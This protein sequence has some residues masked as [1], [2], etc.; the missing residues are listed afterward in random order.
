MA[1]K[2]IIEREKKKIK[3]VDKYAS[4]RAALKQEQKQAAT[5]E[6]KMD[7]PEDIEIIEIEEI[8]DIFNHVFV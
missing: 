6:E 8:K 7:I 1:R 4:K 2:S 5:F 3:L